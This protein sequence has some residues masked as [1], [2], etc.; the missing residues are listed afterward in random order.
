[1][2]VPMSSGLQ[3]GFW[4]EKTEF[5]QGFRPRLLSNVMVFDRGMHDGARF[6][7]GFSIL[8]RG[9]GFEEAVC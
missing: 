1:M 6:G 7:V 2:K 3:G 4:A 5:S 8:F 9:R